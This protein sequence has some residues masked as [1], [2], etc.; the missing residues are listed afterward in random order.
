[1]LISPNLFYSILCIYKII[2]KF[3]TFALVKNL[4]FTLFYFLK[5]ICLKL[6]KKKFEKQTSLSQK[7]YDAKSIFELIEL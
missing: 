2:T 1:M 4:K 7:Y 6:S 5:K 3:Q